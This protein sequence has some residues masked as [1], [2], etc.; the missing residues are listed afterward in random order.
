MET[1]AHT[2]CSTSLSLATKYYIVILPRLKSELS[3]RYHSLCAYNGD[4]DMFSSDLTD[5]QLRLKLGHMTNTPCQVELPN[6]KQ[7]MSNCLFAISLKFRTLKRG[8]QFSKIQK[9]TVPY[10]PL[11]KF[12]FY[13]NKILKG[14]KWI[15]DPNYRTMGLIG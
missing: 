10:Y 15:K 1:H 3:C 4:D 2:F 9:K 6:F 5:D 14:K 8:I 7:H 11:G 13:N 12:I